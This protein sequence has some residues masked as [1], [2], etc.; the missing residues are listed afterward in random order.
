MAQELTNLPRFT[1]YAKIIEEKDGEQKVK[2]AKIQTYP[3]PEILERAERDLTMVIG[4]GYARSK[5]RSEI[6]VEIRERQGSGGLIRP[7]TTNGHRK[8]HY[9]R[10]H[11]QRVTNLLQPAIH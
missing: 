4:N 8:N 5:K 7:Q 3:L 1:A 2:T 6:E 10:S 11:R 9:P